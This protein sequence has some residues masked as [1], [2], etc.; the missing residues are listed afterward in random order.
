MIDT[1]RH[2]YLRHKCRRR[3]VAELYQ[4]AIYVHSEATLGPIQEYEAVVEKRIS[5]LGLVRRPAD[6]PFRPLYCSGPLMLL[7]R[8]VLVT[9]AGE[10]VLNH[11]PR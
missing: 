11:L 4:P 3:H 7:A 10:D 2:A 1:V 6:M 8:T 9:G 5:Q